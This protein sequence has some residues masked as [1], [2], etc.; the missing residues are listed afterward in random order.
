MFATLRVTSIRAAV[1]AVIA[2]LS[3]V[4]LCSVTI[5][6]IRIDA[7][8]LTGDVAPGFVPSA[9]FSAGVRDDGFFWY[10]RPFI[11]A[12]G[13]VVFAGVA[14]I[15]PPGENYDD[16]AWVSERNGGLQ[17]VARESRCTQERTRSLAAACRS[18]TTIGRAGRG[19]VRRVAGLQLLWLRLRRD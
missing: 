5:A 4:I 16:G 15:T 2:T 11:N 8:A 12:A 9:G 18:M 7:V 6:Q 14:H 10:R 1:I 13:E 17:M 19:A 3:T